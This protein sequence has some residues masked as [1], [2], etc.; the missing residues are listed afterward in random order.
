MIDAFFDLGLLVLAIIILVFAA[1]GLASLINIPPVIGRTRMESEE[2]NEGFHAYEI[3]K[4]REN[5]P[6]HEATTDWLDWERGFL[7]AATQDEEG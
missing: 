3:G 5:N 7:A 6:Y 4:S 1:F 2:Y